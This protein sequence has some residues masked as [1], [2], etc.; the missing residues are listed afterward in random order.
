MG[1]LEMAKGVS[2]SVRAGAWHRQQQPSRAPCLAVEL[3]EP[4]GACYLLTHKAE[5]NKNLN[6]LQSQI[7]NF[8]LLTLTSLTA[9]PRAVLW[10]IPKDV[11]LNNTFAKSN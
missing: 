6:H 5:T 7:W 9:A 1:T 11:I 4:L 10:F 8:S 2:K 3:Q